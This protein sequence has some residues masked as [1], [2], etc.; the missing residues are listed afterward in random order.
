MGSWLWGTA[1]V[2]LLVGGARAEEQLH[3][4]IHGS[5]GRGY[6]IAVQRFIVSEGAEEFVEPFYRE[7]ANALEFSSVFK[8]NYWLNP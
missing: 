2:L 4:E 3:V 5:G 6:Q 1:L 7:L 8:V